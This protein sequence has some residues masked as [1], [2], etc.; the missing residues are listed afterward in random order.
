[1]ATDYQF[2]FGNNI[3]DIL[4]EKYPKGYLNHY[5]TMFASQFDKPSTDNFMIYTD[6]YIQME[7]KK[8]FEGLKNEIKNIKK[9]NDLNLYLKFANVYEMV[10]FKTKQLEDMIKVIENFKM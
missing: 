2:N 6:L 4:D 7:G 10:D 8:E 5:I 1:M 9:N 3:S